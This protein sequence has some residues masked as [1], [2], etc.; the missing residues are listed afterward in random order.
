MMKKR[1]IVYSEKLGLLLKLIRAFPLFA[2]HRQDW[3]ILRP[4][5][6]CNT[7]YMNLLIIQHLFP[8]FICMI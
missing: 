3:D 4:Y 5:V 1:I 2:F 6:V 7:E 8:Y